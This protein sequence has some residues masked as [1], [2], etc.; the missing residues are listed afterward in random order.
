[1]LG[2]PDLCH[3]GA[4]AEMRVALSQGVYDALM[5]WSQ[6]RDMS[7]GDAVQVILRDYLGVVKSEKVPRP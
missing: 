1:V 7:P 6:E 2:L 5:A 3:V 4:A